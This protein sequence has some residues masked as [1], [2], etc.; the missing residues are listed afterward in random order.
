MTINNI[1]LFG[2]VKLLIVIITVCISL[3]LV[4]TGNWFQGHWNNHKG[5][6]QYEVNRVSIAYTNNLDDWVCNKCCNN[7]CNSSSTRTTT[8]RECDLSRWRIIYTTI[9]YSK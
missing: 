4:F 8:T 2:W 9:I 1:Y 5:V 6:V 7:C 3:C